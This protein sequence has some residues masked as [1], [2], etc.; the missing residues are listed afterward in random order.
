MCDADTTND[1]VP[2]TFTTLA[3]DRGDTIAFL[4]V[5]GVVRREISRRFPHGRN[6]MV[7][8]T[9]YNSPANNEKTL[10]N[11]GHASTG[12]QWND[13]LV[14]DHRWWSGH[15]VV[16]FSNHGDF[17]VGGSG[18]PFATTKGRH[19]AD[20]RVTLG[21]WNNAAVPATK[22]TVR[23]VKFKTCRMT[24]IPMR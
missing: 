11:A 1:G 13:P 2:D 9:F 12:S 15:T 4:A 8:Q 19:T 3:V 6:S 16:D 18:A 22:L 10:P 14:P 24:A 23:Q 21:N 17:I 5:D 7:G 20:I